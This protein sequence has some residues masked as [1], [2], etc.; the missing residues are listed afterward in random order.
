MAS[1]EEHNQRNEL[2]IR[3]EELQGQL[4]KSSHISAEDKDLLGKM[5]VGI[6]QLEDVQ[7]PDAE[8]VNEQGLR[9]TLEQKSLEYEAQHPKLAFTLR[10]IL[11][12]LARMGI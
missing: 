4:I 12:V 9:D 3:L 7:Q 6:L 1:S 5:V 11:D 8:T 2:K 10:Q